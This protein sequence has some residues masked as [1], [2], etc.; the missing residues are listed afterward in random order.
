MK[1]LLEVRRVAQV[2][3]KEAL[4][5]EKVVQ[6]LEREQLALARVVQAPA[7][8]PAERKQAAFQLHR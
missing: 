2:L 6:E 8:R 5:L 7:E 1:A 3:Q 4:E